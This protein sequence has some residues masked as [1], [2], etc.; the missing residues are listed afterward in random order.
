MSPCPFHRECPAGSLCDPA[1]EEVDDLLRQRSTG[2]RRPPPSGRPARGSRS[3]Q[4]VIS[5]SCRRTVCGCSD[6]NSV[7]HRVP[8]KSAELT[9][10]GPEHEHGRETKSR[11]VE[12]LR[13]V[14]VQLCVSTRKPELSASQ[15]GSLTH[16]PPQGL[17]KSFSRSEAKQFW[18]GRVPLAVPLPRTC[19]STAPADFK[20][21][22]AG[23]TLT[24]QCRPG[25]HD[26]ATF[27]GRGSIPGLRLQG[28]PLAGG[29]VV[30]EL[31]ELLSQPELWRRRGEN[32]P[33]VQAGG[34][35]APQCRP[36]LRGSGCS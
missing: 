30:D 14:L 31:R 13:T 27:R 19:L 20:L 34:T 12:L 11:P 26:A 36:G 21:V 33:H 25:S 2:L 4:F 23:G 35:L 32:R 3:P 10:S 24:P 15:A 22:Q 16:P 29:D 1:R 7:S 5:P 18:T 9:K 8:M 6:E 17:T 28:H